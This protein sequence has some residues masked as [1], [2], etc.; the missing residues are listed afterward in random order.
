M[1]SRIWCGNTRSPLR[2]SI[3]RASS[4]GSGRLP[5]V[6][7]PP[8]PTTTHP[9]QL[10]HAM[11]SRAQAL[12]PPCTH[13]LHR[14][15]RTSRSPHTMRRIQIHTAPTSALP[16]AGVIGV[17]LPACAPATRCLAVADIPPA[18]FEVA[19]FVAFLIPAAFSTVARAPIAPAA[20]ASAAAI[21]ASTGAVKAAVAS[22]VSGSASVAG[23]AA[24]PAPASSTTT[25]NS[26]RQTQRLDHLLPR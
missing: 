21:A 6:R 4:S 7:N 19:A 8:P 12:P 18:V 11:H 17:V 1:G 5:R 16:I 15:R 9:S 3:L 22:P 14:A 13:I 20:A 10:L 25:S 2:R 23:L 24:V 26:T